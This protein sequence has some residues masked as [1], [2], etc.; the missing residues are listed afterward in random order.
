M[1]TQNILFN[2]A[3]ICLCITLFSIKA[4]AKATD[5]VI[6]DEKAVYMLEGVYHK[7]TSFPVKS[8][9][10]K[11]IIKINLQDNSEETF[12]TS[13]KSL[14]RLNLS[15]DNKHLAVLKGC[16]GEV[17]NM[18]EIAIINIKE[19]REVLTFKDKFNRYRWSPDGGKIIYI[20][21]EWNESISFF[22]KGIWIYDIEKREKRKIAEMGRDKGI[23]EYDETWSAENIEWFTDDNI[24]IINSFK[25]YKNGKDLIVKNSYIYSYKDNEIKKKNLGAVTFS[26]DGRYFNAF[27]PEY[28]RYL[29]GGVEDMKM[30][31][32]DI[33]DTNT[34]KIIPRNKLTNIFDD[35]KNIMWETLFWLANNRILIE[36]NIPRSHTWEFLIGDIENNKILKRIKGE[37][38]AGTN[39]NRSKFVIFHKGK[40][41]V[42]DVP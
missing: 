36:K 23:I 6:H 21:N 42:V 27:S 26:L 3:L 4:F 16:S 34:G 2:I 15:P 10:F 19:K 14:S 1:K 33:F 41:T 7:F 11:K 24:Y 8:Y 12:F 35:P 32:V 17:E 37:Y 22:S 30:I 9:N 18:C 29:P 40:I 31:L 38:L 20:N 5:I 25:G 39:A 28:I 13:S